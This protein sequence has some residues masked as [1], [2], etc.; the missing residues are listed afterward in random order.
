MYPRKS[1]ENKEFLSMPDIDESL[2][3]HF[4]RGFFDAD[5]SV[6]KMKHRKNLIKIDIT[7]NSFKF[8][9]E[10]NN[11]LIK[12]NIN[13]WKIITKE[14]K[15]VNRKVY[16][17]IHFTKQNE[18]HNFSDYIYKDSTIHLKRKYNIFSNH[19]IIDKVL[20]RNMICMSCD[21]QNI[22]RNGIRNNIIRYKCKD[23]GKGFSM[24]NM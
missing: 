5:G 4:I 8:I 18:V 3:H 14:P 7:S 6:Y 21:S 11:E 9:N 20:E 10:L 19:K 12:N 16:Y 13:C 15:R 24:K 23:C 22:I 2:I 1:Y 17:I